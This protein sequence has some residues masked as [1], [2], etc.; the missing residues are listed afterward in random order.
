MDKHFFISVTPMGEDLFATI[1]FDITEQKRTQERYQLISENAAD[2][3]WMWDL[4]EGRC[5][6]VSHRYSS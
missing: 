3:I 4:E 1:F 6:Y 2:V 5:A